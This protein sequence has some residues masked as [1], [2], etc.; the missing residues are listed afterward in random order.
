VR[1]EAENVLP[2]IV[3]IR[4]SS[5]VQLVSTCWQCRHISMS[6]LGSIITSALPVATVLTLVETHRGRR[7]CRTCLRQ[8]RRRGGGGARR[9]QQ[10]LHEELQ[11]AQLALHGGLR[12]LPL[13]V[14]LLRA[15]SATT[16]PGW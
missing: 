15:R 10:R 3:G 16:T 14:P 2:I 12:S 7:C 8:R 9:L 1:S 6:K 5:A 11:V 4:D 13:R